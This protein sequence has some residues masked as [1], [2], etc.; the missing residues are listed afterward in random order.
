MRITAITKFKHAAIYLLMKELC[1]TQFELSKRAGMSRFLLARI[2]NLTKAPSEDEKS[3]IQIAFGE[4]G[5]YL[6]VV[7]AFPADYKPL[8]K[9]V[10]IE[11]TKDVPFNQLDYLETF[12]IPDRPD[13]IA[14]LNDDLRYGLEG[15]TERQMHYFCERFNG[16]SDAD[17][18]RKHS[19]CRTTVA[20]ISRIACSKVEHRL[21]NEFKAAQ[22][23]RIK[24]YAQ[25]Q[26]P[27]P[28][29]AI[30]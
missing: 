18:A 1:W 2:L 19:I 8:K 22:A 25:S 7:E 4:A 11:Q 21:K 12:Q 30:S 15:L 16:E 10:V 14:A 17:I 29:N 20:P 13:E 3:K 6:D 27:V 28:A 24:K 26:N 23:E 9:R 5:K